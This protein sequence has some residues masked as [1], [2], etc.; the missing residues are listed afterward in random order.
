MDVLWV[1]D[2]RLSDMEIATPRRAV[3][4]QEP[5]TGTGDAS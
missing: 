5:R 1:L 4:G 2:L 3:R